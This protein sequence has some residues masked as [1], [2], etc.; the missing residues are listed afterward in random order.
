MSKQLY[1]LPFTTQQS[2]IDGVI[3]KV[4]T[5]RECY[6]V[7][8]VSYRLLPTISSC[9]KSEWENGCPIFALNRRVHSAARTFSGPPISLLTGYDLHCYKPSLLGGRPSLRGAAGNA[10]SCSQRGNNRS[11]MPLDVSGC[12]RATLSAAASRL[13]FPLAGKLNLATALVLGTDGC[14]RPS[15]TRNS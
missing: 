13:G 4:N 1:Q 3:K 12:I 15:R 7:G 14:I 10:S 6:F 11:V 2:T 9:W 8:E 5:E